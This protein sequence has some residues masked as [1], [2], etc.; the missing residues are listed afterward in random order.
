MSTHVKYVAPNDIL[1]SIKSLTEVV[2]ELKVDGLSDEDKNQLTK[3]KDDMTFELLNQRLGHYNY[4]Y[5]WIDDFNKNL[6]QK[7]ERHENFPSSISENIAKFAICKYHGIMPTWH[8]KKGDLEIHFSSISFEQIEVKGFMSDGP[9]SFGPAEGWHRIYF[10]D[11]KDTL[12][13][14][15][16]VY[17]I[18]LSNTCETWKNIKLSGCV[19]EPENIEDLPENLEDLEDNKKWTVK[20]LKQLC[21]SRGLKMVGK[22]GEKKVELIDRL[23]TQEPGSGLPVPQT[24]GDIAKK[25]KRGKLRGSF[26]KIFKPQLDEHCKLIFDG[27]I[28]ELNNTI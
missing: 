2:N 17:E 22:K 20:K 15:F 10:V 14:R 8:T 13:N 7:K 19:M 1:E 11:G 5:N 12:N 9:L 3:L 18:N 6:S 16:K 4:N 28:S 25:D 26:Y 23:K 24:F 21:K 27:H